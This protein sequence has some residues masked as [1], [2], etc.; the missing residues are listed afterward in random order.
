MN[1]KKLSNKIDKIYKHWEFL[2]FQKRIH[3]KTVTEHDA[4]FQWAL[5]Q[6]GQGLPNVTND[7]ENIRSQLLKKY[8]NLYL[9]KTPIKIIIHVP[10]PKISPGGFSVFSNL[11]A[12]LQYIGIKCEHLKLNHNLNEQLNKFK[13]TVLLTSDS[14]DYL[15]KL[16]WDAIKKY[17]EKQKLL[18]GLTA[19]IE[20]YGNTPL[21]VRLDW[22]R[23]NGIDFFY[24][25]R[26]REYTQSR[27]DY[28]PFFDAGY[29]IFNIEFGAN[30]LL[31][32]PVLGIKKDIPYVFFG[33]S[34]SD[35]HKRYLEWFDAL[36][37]ST[38]GFINGYGWKHMSAPIQ[39]ELN[40]FILSRASVGLN[41]HLEEQIE[42][43]CELNE[44]TYTLAACGVPQLID[45]PKLLPDR[46]SSNAFFVAYSPREY[47]ELF[48]YVKHNPDEARKRAA[49]AF[50]EVYERHTTFHR[51]EKLIKELTE[52]M[53]D[54][55]HEA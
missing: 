38:P 42:W 36:F 8:S 2:S 37:I 21:P 17:R 46:F 55:D 4:I 34:N 5:R 52:L 6:S 24:S 45:N 51:A 19:S 7:F 13:P 14:S 33:S 18:I 12:S 41:L 15:N 29:E 44:R 27:A 39:M 53:K 10:D 23:K 31:Y 22:S 43:A 47:T 32:F 48:H 20:A 11:S 49:I 35:K 16:D 50:Q 9:N 40:K 1:L 26:S 28:R 3:H 54:N 30:P 25:F